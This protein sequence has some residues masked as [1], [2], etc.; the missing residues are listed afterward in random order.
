MGRGF[1]SAVS[2]ALWLPSD[3]C[4][5]ILKVLHE[6]GA[7]FDVDYHYLW[8]AY[9]RRSLETVEFI[10]Q[11][12]GVYYAPGDHP[13]TALIS[14]A[15]A[16]GNLEMVEWFLERGADVISTYPAVFSDWHAGPPIWAAAKGGHTE[17]VEFLLWSAQTNVCRRMCRVSTRE[18]PL[19][20]LHEE[21]G[22]PIL[23]SY[24]KAGLR[25]AEKIL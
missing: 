5:P 12:G 10:E 20:K 16:Y 2:Q 15:V 25:R 6:C 23:S 7:R 13:K 21:L 22:M 19:C 14:G 3:K 4:L 18:R 17:V 9:Q 8:L 11:H 24:W 1:S